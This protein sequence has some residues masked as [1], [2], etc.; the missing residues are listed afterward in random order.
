VTLRQLLAAST[1][2]VLIGFF[3]VSGPSL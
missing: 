2:L 1:A 3:I